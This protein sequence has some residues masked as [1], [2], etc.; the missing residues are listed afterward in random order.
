MRASFSCA[1]KRGI[2]QDPS[3]LVQNSRLLERSVLL[4]ALVALL[5]DLVFYT[6]F[7]ASDDAQYLITAET[8]LAGEP[9]PVD[10]ASVRLGMTLP[11]TILSAVTGGR[12]H[13]VSLAFA[14]VH[15]ALVVLAFLLG[16]LVHG[17]A[18]ARIAA[19]LVAICPF[20]YLFAGAI[21]PDLINAAWLALS[22]WLLLVALD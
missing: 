3:R 1:M 21:L 11:M 13:L 5:L 4:P 15:A 8:I 14:T 17:K 9:F 22:L 18:E 10:I 16:R 20:Y 2:E 19:V 7:Y 12:V 6:G